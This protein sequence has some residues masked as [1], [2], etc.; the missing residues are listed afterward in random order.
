ME[1]FETQRNEGR[2]GL[3]EALAWF[4]IGLGVAQ[5]VAPRGLSRLI[6]LDGRGADPTVMRAVGVREIASGVGILG[7]R[8]SAEWLWVRLAG[9]AMDLLLLRAAARAEP[10]AKRNRLA[11]TAAAVAGVAV[12]DFVAGKRLTRGDDSVAE[13]S[14]MRV[15]AAITVK[16]PRDEIYEFW[17]SFENFPRFMI[18]LESVEALGANRSRWTATAPGGRTLSWEAETTEQRPNELVSWRSLPGSDVRNEGSV[19]FLDAPGDRGT[20]VHV[21]L[22]YE[23]PFGKLGALIA[24]FAGEEPQQ[25]VKDDLRR[26]KQIL[27]TGEIVVSEGSPEGQAAGRQ[28][29]MRQRPAQPQPEPVGGGGT[30]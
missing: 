30:R 15:K 26:S 24:K 12:P 13:S 20:E 8:R 7:R 3:A 28:L 16:R 27:E 17:Q 22:R 4:S 25:Q 18:H 9:D 21:D 23:A 2:D 1:R 14:A 10:R 5:L 19:R 6:G 11:V 29:P